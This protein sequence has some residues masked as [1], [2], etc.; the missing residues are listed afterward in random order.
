MA[1]DTAGIRAAGRGENRG[2]EADQGPL[3][4]QHETDQPHA[5]RAQGAAAGLFLALGLLV[6]S[7]AH[8]NSDPLEGIVAPGNTGIGAIYR[9][10]SSPYREA[11]RDNDFLP[12]L[13]YEQEHFYLHSYRGGIR[14]GDKNAG[15]ELFVKRRF[16]G[17]AADEVPGSL[18]PDTGRRGP[19]ADVGLAGHL[20]FG[21]GTAYG[22]LMQDASGLSE[23]TEVRLGYRYEGWWSGRLRVRPYAT[24]AWRDAKLNNYYYGAPG[25][26]AGSGVNLELGAIASYRLA[27]RWQVLAA[28]GLTQYASA[29][30]N[31]PAVDAGSL[32]PSVSLGF[33][34]GFERDA[35]P[36]GS[37]K[38]LI[39]RV[40]QGA[41]TDCDLFPIM[42]FQCG[43]IH[44]QDPTNVFALEIGQKF[45]EGVAGWPLDYAGFVGL[46]RHQEK[47]LQSD[48]WQ[49]QAYLKAYYYGFPWRDSVR[50]RVGMGAGISYAEQ[51]PFS[52]ARDQALRGRDTSKL[53][54]Y[55]DPSID[56]SLGDLV[57]S[58]EWRETYLG[59]GVSHR[60]GI[61]GWSR[62]FNNVNGGS[63][64]IYAFLET[65]F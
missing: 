22:E 20:R 2:H 21:E 12:L 63:N 57:G 26:D 31:S 27:E 47:G 40:Y 45:L 4:P 9:F 18:P 36:A 51:I 23:G 14:L 33:L 3:L 6:A 52:E 61:F 62:L 64:Y 34:Y 28:I 58:R 32:A 41:S 53:L 37:R 29:I 39:M 24:L 44:T 56:I 55:A 10:Q 30:R 49:A 48:S 15:G 16:E 38:P 5:N 19:G 54:V 65:A 8:A 42:T 35:A 13:I 1:L 7:A 17:F 43:S 60:S 25:Y 59:V 46:M 11:Q 50:T